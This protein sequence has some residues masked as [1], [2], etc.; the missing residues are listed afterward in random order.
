LRE[1]V[2]GNLALTGFDDIFNAGKTDF[3]DNAEYIVELPLS[4]LYPPE[5]H[6][7]QVNDDEAMARLVKSVKQYGVREPGLARLRSEGGYE[8]VSGNRRKRACELAGLTTM[9]VVVREMDDDSAAI[10]MVD[11][12]LEQREKL[13]LSERAWAYWV[14]MKAL[15]HNGVKC[16]QNSVDIIVEKTGESKNQIFRL[17]R[18]TELVPDLLDKVIMNP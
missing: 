1:K 12:N 8:L 3:P 4:E 18:L 15:N 10:A 7:F 16:D 11:S 14:K 5:F 2:N 6:P 17:I 13:L 9:P